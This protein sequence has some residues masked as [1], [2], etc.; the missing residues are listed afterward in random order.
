MNKPADGLRTV[1]VF[2][3]AIK[4]SSNVVRLAKELFGKLEDLLREKN[5]AD[6]YKLAGILVKSEDEL[7]IGIREHEEF[8]W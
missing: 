8:I 3:C 4:A 7:N 1:A 2:F 6:L 5:A